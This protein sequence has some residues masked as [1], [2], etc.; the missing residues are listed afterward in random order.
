MT[1]NSIAEETC[2]NVNI[3][4]FQRI[5]GNVLSNAIKYNNRGGEII[6]TLKR[7]CIIDKRTM[8]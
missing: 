7:Q 5:I 8:V 6:V 2:V 3:E 4:D 1:F